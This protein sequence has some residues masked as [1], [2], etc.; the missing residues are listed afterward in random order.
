MASWPAC[1]TTP[2]FFLCVFFRVQICRLVVVHRF[3]DS[4]HRPALAPAIIPRSTTPPLAFASLCTV[5]LPATVAVTLATIR[6]SPAA[7][8]N[9]MGGDPDESTAIDHGVG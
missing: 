3:A 6:A 5:G 1:H 2:A 4:P 8:K 9:M 7:L